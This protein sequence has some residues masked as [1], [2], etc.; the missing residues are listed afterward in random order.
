MDNNI[1]SNE[2]MLFIQFRLKV[3]MMCVLAVLQL[4]ILFHLRNLVI[5]FQHD[6][7]PKHRK[8]RPFSR[9]KHNG[10]WRGVKISDDEYDKLMIEYRAKKEIIREWQSKNLAE[11]PRLEK[12][13]YGSFFWVMNE[14]HRDGW[15]YIPEE[16]EAEEYEDKWPMK[17][18]GYKFKESRT[19]EQNQLRIK[20]RYYRRWMVLFFLP[21]LTLFLK[22]QYFFVSS[23]SIDNFLWELEIFNQPIG[24]MAYLIF[25]MGIVLYHRFSIF[26]R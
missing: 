15:K 7:V 4:Y 26:H 10:R 20:T 6:Y 8:A 18:L 14:K 21:I 3:L 16:E 2:K 9:T 1:I 5:H 24:S 11:H 25:E 12:M 23:S 13:H 22:L 19:F 17:I